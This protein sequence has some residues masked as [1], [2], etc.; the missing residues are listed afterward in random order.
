MSTTLSE[1]SRTVD[2]AGAF[3]NAVLGGVVARE[4]KMDPV[5]FIALAIVSGLGGG[6]IRDTLLQHGPPI[7][8]TD[9]AYVVT[10]AAGATL[11]FLAPLHGRIWGLS[12]PVVDAMAL[13]TWAT[14]GAQK[15]LGVGLGWLPAV[16][17]GTVAAVGGGAVRRHRSRPDP[18]DLR[19]RRLVLDYPSPPIAEGDAMTNHTYRVIGIVGTSP[20]S[21]DAAIRNGLARATETTRDSLGSRCGPSAATW[22][23]GPSHTSGLAKGRLPARGR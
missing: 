22:R 13:G 7:A 3:A 20:D 6:I 11:A 14:V 8:L 16:L 17:L 9:S 21:V 18:S 5:G 15:T 1:L 23:T 19:R 2:L 12:Y 4:L 10:A